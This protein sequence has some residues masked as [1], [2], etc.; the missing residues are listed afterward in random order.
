MTSLEVAGEETS[1]ETA[2]IFKKNHDLSATEH[3]G[4]SK[5][6]KTSF[7]YGLALYVNLCIKRNLG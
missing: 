4:K 7:A 1:P 3:M 2:K 5:S 6:Y